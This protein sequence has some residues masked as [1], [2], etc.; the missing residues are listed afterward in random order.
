MQGRGEDG[1]SLWTLDREMTE[2]IS[3]CELLQA[4]VKLEGAAHQVTALTAQYGLLAVFLSP[5]GIPH[6]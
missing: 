1:R 5:S 3:K 2:G 6:G 4:Q